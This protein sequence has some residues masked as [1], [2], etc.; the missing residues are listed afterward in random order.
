MTD[1]FALTNLTLVMFSSSWRSLGKR[2]RELLSPLTLSD[3]MKT[4]GHRLLLTNCL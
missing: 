3:I 4:S 2:E 1:V